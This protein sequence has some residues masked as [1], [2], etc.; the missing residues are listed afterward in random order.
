M[1]IHKYSRGEYFYFILLKKERM[2]YKMKK[3]LSLILVFVCIFALAACQNSHSPETEKLWES[4]LYSEDT[5][6]GDG[7]VTVKVE[8]KAGEKSVVFT[9]NTN[10]STIGALLGEH[11]LISGDMGEFGI[12]LKSVNG[13]TADY[14]VDRSYWAFYING[15]YAMT[16][17]DQTYIDTGATYLLEYTK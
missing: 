9:I 8:V 13:I 14:D 4:A 1:P 12:Y 15:E 11:N 2:I 5:T 3:T 10:E 6:L 16:G 7:N 17:V